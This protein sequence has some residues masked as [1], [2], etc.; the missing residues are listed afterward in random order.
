MEESQLTPDQQGG[1]SDV[2]G[3]LK[4]AGD[5][6]GIL[7]AHLGNLVVHPAG[8]GL[9]QLQTGLLHPVST[10]QADNGMTGWTV[11]VV[12]GTDNVHL[13]PHRHGGG[14]SDRDTV[15]CHSKVSDPCRLCNSTMTTCVHDI[16]IQNAIFSFSCSFRY[17]LLTQ[18]KLKWST[19]IQ[20]LTGEYFQ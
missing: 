2:S 7:T 10:R 3:A 11:P 1:V 12:P 9:R 17:F 6:A 20:T 14:N 4:S 13:W 18:I 15:H 16:Y 8:R 19:D 5:G